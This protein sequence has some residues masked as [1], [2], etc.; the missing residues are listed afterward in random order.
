MTHRLPRL[1]AFAPALA[2]ILGCGT[3]SA[4]AMAGPVGSYLITEMEVG[5]GIELRADGTY[6]YA[7]TTGALDETSQGTWKAK[8][9]TVTLTTVP[10]PK[11]ARFTP[12]PVPATTPATAPAAGTTTAPY[13]S[14]ALPNGMWMDG[15][16]FTLTCRDEAKVEGYIEGKSWSPAGGGAPC[17]TPQSIEL[18]EPIH[19]IQSEPFPIA[20]GTKALHF[21][22]ELNDIGI[23][24]LTG[25]T[26]VIKGDR[27]TLTRNPGTIRFRRIKR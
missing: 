27:L 12:A 15:I 20:P 26:A 14:V 19:S 6:V 10:V 1:R 18:I 16:A 8:G 7:M 22:F 3:L 21:V 23:K 24:N 9:N 2:L 13:L 17:D 25:A 11:P 5:G 4:T